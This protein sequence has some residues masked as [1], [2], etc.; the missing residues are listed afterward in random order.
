[1]RASIQSLLSE[2]AD[3]RALGVAD[4]AVVAANTLD[5]S[6]QFRPL[7]VVKWSFVNR[8]IGPS[9]RNLLELW[10]YDV[11]GDYTRIDAII[12]R[13]R[14]ILGM[15]AAISDGDGAITQIDWDG[16]GEDGYDDGLSALFRT[17]SFTVIGS[18][19]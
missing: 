5:D 1:M 6:I 9:R 3:L 18:G 10:V 14:E 17:S 8:G 4:G 2:D 15:A 16:D 13:S 11:P 12:N 7:I 19:R